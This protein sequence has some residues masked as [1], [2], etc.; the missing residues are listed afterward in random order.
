MPDSLT[1]L[2]KVRRYLKAIEDGDAAY[3]LSLFSPDAYVEQLPNK[4]YPQGIRTSVSQ[5]PEAFEKGRKIFSRQTYQIKNEAMN[6]NTVALE[7]VWTAKLAIPFGS[8]TAGSE[9][10]AHSAMFIEFRDGKI[11]AQRNYDCFGPW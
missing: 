5:I 6:G 8:V 11:V 2:D 9:L 3:V 7:V 1:N 4:I 10:R